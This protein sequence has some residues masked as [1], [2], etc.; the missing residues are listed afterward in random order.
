MGKGVTFM[1][2]DFKFNQASMTENFSPQHF[3]L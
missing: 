3:K 1:L 2:Q